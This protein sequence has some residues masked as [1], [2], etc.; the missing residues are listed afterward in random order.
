MSNITIGKYTLE[1]LTT[2]MYTDPLILFR[3]YIQNSSDAIDDA[4]DRG[5]ITKEESKINIKL[6][7][8]NREIIIEDNGT[9][10]GKNKAFKI[11]TDIG[12]SQKRFTN[13]KGF[14]GIGRLG[15]LSY[16]DTLIFE[17]S[18]KGEDK[19]TILSFDSLKLS[20]L[21]IPGKY[22]E[23]GMGEVLDEITDLKIIDE[24]IEKH[25]FKVILKNV[26]KK[27]NLLNEEKVVNYIEETAPIPFDIEK[28]EFGKIINDKLKDLGSSIYEYN[29][30]IETDKINR[31]IFKPYKKK[32]YADIK[33]KL[34]DEI[35]GIELKVITDDAKDKIIALAWYGKTELKGTIVEESIKGLRVRKSGI[36]IGDRLLLNSI[37][38]EE[39]FNG[40]ICGEVIV[41]DN[42][43]IPNARRDDFEKNDEYLFLM[44]ELRKLGQ[45]ISN[46]IRDASKIRNHK[47][48]EK[49]QEIFISQEDQA[50]SEIAVDS[51]YTKVSKKISTNGSDVF[52]K[53]DNLIQ[54]I[55]KKK[56]FVD[57][58]RNVLYE[59]N[60]D[61]KIIEKIIKE[62][63]S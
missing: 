63:K 31:Q 48:L 4:I 52:Y 60:I 1:S 26:N 29:V 27:L 58:V 57:K 61:E 37:F 34:T 25:Y 35:T 5:L 54:V 13:H 46:E 55:N 33:K 12:N 24:D 11:L 44:N 47:I 22:E 36:L 21:L 51:E 10:I 19:K 18:S 39:R 28:F 38:K 32:F 41:L 59:N 53:L 6:D 62:I 16:C 43:I 56:N 20:E 50:L 8:S 30:F 40:W 9:G 45:V 14:R 23:F 2:G 17:T 42:S 3:E 49:K 7:N 15:G